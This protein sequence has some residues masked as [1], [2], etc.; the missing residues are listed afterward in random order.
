MKNNRTKLNLKLSNEDIDCSS[1]SG[2]ATPDSTS[3]VVNLK[4]N[5][6]EDLSNNCISSIDPVSETSSFPSSQ[7]SFIKGKIQ[8]KQ[9]S[10]NQI[11]TVSLREQLSS[12]NSNSKRLENLPHS[13]SRRKRPVKRII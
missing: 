2:K 8:T 6:S 11:F 3:F 5:G 4:E 7:K 13:E 1:E 9:S 12:L 10:N